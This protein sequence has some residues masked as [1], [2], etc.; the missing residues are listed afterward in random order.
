MNIEFQNQVIILMQADGFQI[1]AQE[2]KADGEFHRCQ[3]KNK[4]RPNQDCSYIIHDKMRNPVAYWHNFRTEKD[5]KYIA[6]GNKPLTKREQK[7]AQDLER[8]FYEEVRKE[9]ERRYTDAAIRAN[10]IWNN[11]KEIE[12]GAQGDVHPYLRRKKI[13]AFGIRVNEEGKLLIPI[14]NE[15]NQLQS[16]QF[17]NLLG[18]KKNL[19]KAKMTGGYFVIPPTEG[20]DS[21]VILI[22]EGYATGA[23]LHM[24]SGLETWISFGIGN[25]ANVAKILDKKYPD[26]KKVFC[27]DNDNLE[28]GA[29]KLGGIGAKKAKEACDLIGNSYLAICPITN[30]KKTDFNDLH[31]EKGLEEVAHFIRDVIARDPQNVCTIPA[32]YLLIKDG[33]QSGLYYKGK[34]GSSMIRI[35]DAIEVLANASTG[36]RNGW[37]LEVRF[38][39][40]DGKEQKKIIRYA[41]IQGKPTWLGILSDGGWKG[42]PNYYSLVQKY[43]LA[44]SPTRRVV[45]VNKIG[46]VNER[47]Y[48][49]PGQTYGDKRNEEYR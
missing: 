14:F 48:V 11:A 42:D 49:L 4:G 32:N 30:D 9:Q 3:D 15:S 2:L 21:D 26:K 27:A 41:D 40:P 37:G 23:S 19:S 12:W 18:K 28:D 6:G 24:A 22:A 20:A 7:E 47:C 46:W 5:G 38:L 17:I 8:V 10:K 31:V 29:G 36:D 16:I 45:L 39:D 25:L 43:L 44:V 33:E 35:G 34:D 1:A 13:A